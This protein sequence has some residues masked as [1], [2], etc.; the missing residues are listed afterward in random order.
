MIFRNLLLET[1]E[2]TQVRLI[3]HNTV[4]IFPRMKSIFC[5]GM[6]PTH[7][8]QS[9]QRGKYFHPDRDITGGL[10]SFSL[11]SLGWSC[12]HHSVSTHLLTTQ[13]LKCREQV[14]SS[15]GQQ[16]LSRQ[17]QTQVTWNYSRL[18]VSQIHSTDQQMYSLTKSSKI[19]LQICLLWWKTYWQYEPYPCHL[20]SHSKLLLC[21]F[22]A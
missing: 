12:F 5:R 10:F 18:S 19:P 22:F 4:V 1:F 6:K 8:V 15:S 11:W 20:L 9:V 17:D 3:W 7:S 2:E 14:L 16:L 21:S 13:S